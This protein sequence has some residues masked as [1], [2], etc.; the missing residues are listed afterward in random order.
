[1]G[2]LEDVVYV[3]LLASS[4]V[5]QAA[6]RRLWGHDPIICG[7]RAKLV[8]MQNFRLQDVQDEYK[9][10]SSFGCCECRNI[11]ALCIMMNGTHFEY[12]LIMLGTS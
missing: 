6:S 5:R 8:E 12:L 4:I 1:M 9:L 7:H 11:W 10:D 2:V 3:T